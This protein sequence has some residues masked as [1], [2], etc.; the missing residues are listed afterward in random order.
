[1]ANIYN[2]V[3][4]TAKEKW[5]R[6]IYRL[7]EKDLGKILSD[8]EDKSFMLCLFCGNW[9]QILRWNYI[10]WGNHWNVESIEGP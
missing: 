8:S 10:A 5:N 6:Y 3:L 4:F 7:K 9:L 1:M 2:A